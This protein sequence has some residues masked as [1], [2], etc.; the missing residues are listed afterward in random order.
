MKTNIIY[1]LILF[2][3]V[4]LSVTAQQTLL[5]LQNN[6]KENCIS[7]AQMK[8]IAFRIEQNKRAAEAKGTP[9]PKVNKTQS[10]P[11]LYW[12]LKAADNFKDESLYFVNNY[13]DR[14]NTSPGIQDYN[15]GTRTYDGHNGMDID[16]V[17]FHWL[18]MDNQVAD[19]IAAAPGVIA[20]SHD[21]EFDRN[22]TLNP[23]ASPNYVVV[24]HADGSRA[25]YLHMK[26]GSVLTKPIGSVVN[27]GD[28]LG[29]V[30]SSGYSTGPHLHFEIHDNLNNVVDPN[31]GTCNTNSSLWAAQK[32]YWESGVVRMMTAINGY[33]YNTCPSQETTN[34]VNHFIPSGTIRLTVFFRGL[35]TNQVINIQ[36]YDEQGTQKYNNNSTYTGANTSSTA[37]TYQYTFSSSNSGTWKMQVIYN[38][39][40]Y[41]HYFTVFCNTYTT[42]NQTHT[43]NKGFIAEG[44][45]TSISTCANGS[46][47][48]YEAESEIVLSDGF[49]A[50]NGS[51][52][53][54][55]IDN[56]IV[57][58]SRQSDHAAG[59][60][61]HSPY[62]NTGITLN[63]K[64]ALLGENLEIL[65]INPNPFT[66]S[67]NLTINAKNT[68]KAEVS[69]FNSVGVKVKT[70]PVINAAK[71]N[72]KI[73]VD[74]SSFAKGVYLVEV[75]MGEEKIIK[76]V[77]K[78]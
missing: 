55:N 19:I 43:G 25:F 66:T 44:S 53:R 9:F 26:N 54:T 37:S 22:C 58:S 18:M 40:V 30:G 67:F 61:N 62:I 1:L 27:T 28:Y 63:S 4:S 49:F 34:E 11:A 59:I 23:S 42:L 33:S 70:L 73:N 78:L 60:T 65:S 41:N 8:L 45:L 31:N 2:G 50:T 57:Y 68:T 15:C 12:P 76:K 14:D 16:L 36:I 17:P 7:K 35:Q 32:D 13:V 24:E 64:K 38:G 39:K 47:V 72:N 69:I 46:N 20:D 6:T 5:P 48:W 74:G 77:I 56:C 52:F 29:K 51:T 21:G 75:R 10:I 3:L 71:G